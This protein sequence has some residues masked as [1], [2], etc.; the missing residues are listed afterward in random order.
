M[1]V[2]I[3]ELHSRPSRDKMEP[4]R[5]APQYKRG[6]IIEWLKREYRGNKPFGGLWTSTR[7]ADEYQCD[8][9]RGRLTNK[10]IQLALPADYTENLQVFELRPVETARMREIE[11]FEDALEFTR[12]FHLATVPLPGNLRA[13]PLGK[14][15]SGR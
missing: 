12:E 4:V 8:W 10:L 2:Q 3:V 11:S 5:N 9:R 13:T 15:I 7:T 1:I 6:D 14:T